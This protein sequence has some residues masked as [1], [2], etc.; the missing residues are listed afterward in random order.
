MPWNGTA[1]N[2]YHGKF[3]IAYMLLPKQ[4]KTIVCLV[5][6][7]YLKGFYGISDFTCKVVFVSLMSHMHI[8]STVH[9]KGR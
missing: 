7:I 2:G 1:K 3:Y 5:R 6:C 9:L 8:K 4:N